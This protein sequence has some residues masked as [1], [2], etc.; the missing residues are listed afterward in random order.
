[1]GVTLGLLWEKGTADERTV[2]REMQRP[3]REPA[4]SSAHRDLGLP[5]QQRQEVTMEAR[6]EAP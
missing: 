5:M 1:M 6:I 2:C 4:H 3:E